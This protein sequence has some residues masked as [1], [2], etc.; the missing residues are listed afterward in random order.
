MSVKTHPLFKTTIVA[1]VISSLFSLNA[2]TYLNSDSDTEQVTQNKK[3]QHQAEK[4]V[5]KMTNDEKLKMLVGA[6][7]TPAQSDVVNLGSVVPGVAGYIHGVSDP[8]AGI[9]LP[10][11][12]LA[13]GPA[14]V[15]IDP[16][17]NND[18][19]TYYTT[20]FPTG[21]LLASTWNTDLIR[22]VGKAIGNE[23]R[24]YGVDFW[25]APG[26]NIQRNPLLGRNFEYF[27]EDPL[28]A[29]MMASAIVNG[30]QSEGVATT[31]KH[32]AA[33]NSE[34]N[35]YWVNAVVTPRA[36]REIY[37][38]GFRY[39]VQES[40]P[41]ALMTSYNSINGQNA[42]ERQDLIT[43]VLRNEWGYDGLVMSDWFAGQNPVDL[44]NAGTDV[45]QPGGSNVVNQ[46]IGQDLGDWA[47]VVKAGYQSGKISQATLDRNVQHLVSQMLQTPSAAHYRFSSHPD[48]QSHAKLSRQAADEGI[49]LLKN[50]GHAL[51][52]SPSAKVASFG[53]TQLN[54]Y[55]GGTGSG[56]VHSPYVINIAQGLD[57]RFTLNPSLQKFYDQY[58][59]ANKTV[60]KGIL[61]ISDIVSCPEP[62]G[63]LK[64]LIHKSAQ[65]SDA[66][67]ITLGRN[68]GEDADRQA[69]RGDY[70]LSKDEL[71]LIQR[72]S[73]A[74]H[75]QH[76]KV[77][78]VLNV[79][80]VTDVSEWRD[81]VDGI[82]L[83]YM[84]GQETGNAV[85]D[86]LS[87]DVNPSG[88][89]A[90]SFP[91]HYKDVPSAASAR[92]FPGIDENG[93][94]VL[95]SEYYNE[96]IYVGYRYYQTFKKPV[97]YPF[98]YGLSYTTFDIHNATVNTNAL[99]SEHNAPFIRLQATVTNTGGRKG[100]EVAQVY[101]AAPEVKLKKPATE[102]KAFAKTL[103]LAP[104]QSQDIQFEIPAQTLASFDS[105]KNQWIVEPG[106][107]QAYIS[108]SSD[109][110]GIQPVSFSVRRELVVSQTTPGALALPKGITAAS[111][112]TVKK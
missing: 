39:A 104:G 66:A 8:D 67:V 2:C 12:R 11:V 101:I 106:T 28:V 58:F 112:V 99:S 80:G 24:E 34:T 88:K 57:K 79:T 4:I 98:G 18:Q 48:L 33:N 29:G 19:Q 35:R 42:G 108:S 74:F 93:D 95:D 69:V 53:I 82:V 72:V 38:R 36:L 31:I 14:G 94:A 21:T 1:G 55:K 78:V 85:A 30:A 68:A 23:A 27:S 13:D 86:I 59:A 73:K 61:G 37:L 107:Y 22:Q 103:T 87:G 96:D 47:D 102:L 64:S 26:M 81:Q 10:A 50:T 83:A 109:M 97:A 44:V 40:H 100:K 3:A 54:T 76:K 77:I 7:M 6:G 20:A 60:K 65:T 52:L 45:I 105:A 51:P 62:V 15:R 84:P 90:Q 111:F 9:D 25:L 71:R 63:Q 91:L 75:A 5:A 49:I 89:L 17:R 92:N 32:F 16:A 43:G 46:R 41:Q 70:L 56:D 110:T